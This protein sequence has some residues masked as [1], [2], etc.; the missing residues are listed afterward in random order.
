M[1]RLPAA[2]L[3]V[4]LLLLA[5]SFVAR[6]PTGAAV[7]TLPA[8]TAAPALA[9]AE[10]GRALFQAKGCTSCHQH[11]GLAISRVETRA[12][13]D[14]DL[15]EAVG[16]PDLTHYRPDPAFVRQWLRDPAAVRPDTQMPNLRLSDEEIEALLAFLQTNDA[17]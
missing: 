11:A 13:A 5:L 10:L 9:P 14:L 8:A 15:G 4:A 17:P 1:N 3:V 7:A 6:R 2:L 16:A 12:A